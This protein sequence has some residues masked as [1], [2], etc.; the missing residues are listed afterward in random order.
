M[1]V[2]LHKASRN[3]CE[4]ILEMQLKSFADLLY[5]YQD[6]EISPGNE[7]IES[8]YRRFDQD[9]TDYHLIEY[10][11]MTVGAVRIITN[12]RENTCRISPVFILPE[13]QGNG[14]AQATFKLLEEIYYKYSLWKLDTILQERGNCHLYEKLGYIRTGKYEVI[15]DN[16]TIVYYEK[17]M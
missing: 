12:E 7:T 1:N 14:I 6:Y 11:S 15:K 13:Y 5:K 8:I 3:D 2:K 17:T 10:N 16:M 9:F 4:L